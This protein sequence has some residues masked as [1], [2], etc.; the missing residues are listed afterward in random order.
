MSIA[1]KHLQRQLETKRAGKR[2]QAI[3]ALQEVRRVNRTLQN[4]ENVTE[5]DFDVLSDICSS[6]HHAQS[7]LERI[8]DAERSVR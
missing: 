3:E 4:I 7:N 6:L 1:V 5:L 2:A 8:I